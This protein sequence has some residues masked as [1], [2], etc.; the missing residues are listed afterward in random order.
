[1]EQMECYV[2]DDLSLDDHQVHCGIIKEEFD[3]D[4]GK[5][6]YLKALDDSDSEYNQ[7]F[8]EGIGFFWK[9]LSEDDPKIS[10]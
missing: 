10:W 2:L 3:P 1:M 7:E 4:L 5:L 9:I 6:L 8:E